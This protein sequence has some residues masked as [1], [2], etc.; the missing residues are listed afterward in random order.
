MKIIIIRHGEPSP[1]DHE[2]TEQGIKEASALRDF[3]ANLK[4]DKIYTSPLHRALDTC[5]IFLENKRGN[6]EICPWLAEFVHPV[7]INGKDVLN[8]DFMPSF[9]AKY[10]NLYNP[11]TYLETEVMKSGKVKE[12]YDEVI[13]NFDEILKDNGYERYEKYYKVN[14]S[15]EKTIIFFCHFGMMCVL[16]SHLSNIPYSVL[17]Q[18][19]ICL[20]TGMTV[21]TS[22][23]REKGIAQFRCSQFGD[24]SHLKAFGIEPSFHGRFCETFESNQRH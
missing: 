4:F 23:E 2:L 21:I 22:E 5:R 16:L 19:F 18:H 24:I 9:Y 6:Y 14:K 12:F 3:Y 10:D 1:I 11:N 20:P 17:A 15:N 8:W 13:S 7:K